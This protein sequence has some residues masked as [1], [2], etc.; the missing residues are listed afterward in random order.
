MTP[1]KPFLRTG[2]VVFG[3][4]ILL[5]QP[6]WGADPSTIKDEISQERLRLEQLNQEIAETQKKAM[7]KSR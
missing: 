5:I 1:F 3:L 4:L 2:V 7:V 6:G